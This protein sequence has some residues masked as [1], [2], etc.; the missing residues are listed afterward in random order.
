[1]AKIYEKDC[2]Y[3]NMGKKGIYL[4]CV[5]RERERKP[6]DFQVLDCGERSCFLTIVFV[7]FYST[8]FVYVLYYCVTIKTMVFPNSGRLGFVEVNNQI[9]GTR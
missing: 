1:M 3:E 4:M 7:L 2:V 8:T 6:M 9:C 5:E